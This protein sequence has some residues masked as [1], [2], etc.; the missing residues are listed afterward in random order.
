MKSTKLRTTT[1][2]RRRRATQR[3]RFNS[4][5]YSRQSCV[6]LSAETG[7]SLTNRYPW[8]RCPHSFQ[9]HMLL[10]A[11]GFA[12]LPCVKA[13]GVTDLPRNPR[14][15]PQYVHAVPLVAQQSGKGLEFV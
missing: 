1:Y 11:S 6:K 10:R 5:A 3:L 2:A 4:G 13:G 14:R 12:R 8:F 15:E 7:Q 9:V